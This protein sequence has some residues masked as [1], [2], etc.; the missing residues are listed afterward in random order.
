M[1]RRWAARAR[2]AGK[3]VGGVGKS[4]RVV[5]SVQKGQAGAGRWA[6]VGVGGRCRYKVMVGR[7]ERAVQCPSPPVLQPVPSP[8]DLPPGRG[9]RHGG[10]VGG[11][12]GA[13]RR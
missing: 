8:S 13:D 9:G 5:G 4:G 3:G 6:G 10:G 1:S 7:R 12:A 11:G 2:Q